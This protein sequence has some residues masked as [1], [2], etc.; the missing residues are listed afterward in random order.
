[1]NCS[2]QTRTVGAL[3]ILAIG[4]AQHL[5]SAAVISASSNGY[6]LSASATALGLNVSAGPV[7]VGA[8]GTAPA[9]YNNPQTLLNLNVVNSIPFVVSGD[10]GADA[11]NGAAASDV[12]GLPGVRTTSASGGVVGADMDLLTLPLFRSGITLFG[13]GATLGSTA[14]ITG[15][16]GSLVATGT[17]TI[18]NLGLTIN[19]INVPLGTYVGV[20]VAPNT[21]VNLAGL[22]IANA[23]LILNEQ[24]IAGDNSSITVNAFHLS[25]NIANAITSNVILGHS[26]ASVV[27]SPVPEPSTLAMVG[28]GL[29]TTVNWRRRAAR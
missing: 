4:G 10:I 22:G 15:D 26:Q 11:V 16:H 6:G 9:P 21:M 25:V 19:A 17:T 14:Q 13:L 28:L 27:T 2:I 20:N 5:A 29:V 12:D 7:P 24:I 23:S 18:E 3:L 8:S 1:M